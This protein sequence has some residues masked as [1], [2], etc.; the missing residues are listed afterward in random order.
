M[1]KPRTS[2]YDRWQP[3]ETPRFQGVFGSHRTN[4]VSEEVGRL[5]MRRL[6][7]LLFAVLLCLGVGVWALDAGGFV[8]GALLALV[9]F[10][11]IRVLDWG[12][13]EAEP[14]DERD[15]DW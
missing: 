10:S 5:L 14:A 3:N 11:F 7:Y 2:Q 15:E 13:P 6:R 8:K 1:T 4:D 12:K 9:A